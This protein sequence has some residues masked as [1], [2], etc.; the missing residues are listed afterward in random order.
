LTEATF[1]QIAAA[2]TALLGL[3]YSL[4]G[5]LREQEMQIR[6]A[7]PSSVPATR[8][9]QAIEQRKVATSYSIAAG[10]AGLI[11]VPC[12]VAVVALILDIDPQRQLSFGRLTFALVAV[13]WVVVAT[14]LAVAATRYLRST[15]FR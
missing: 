7:L 10:A 4:S 12:A 1:F 6:R 3:A 9:R 15:R 14:R 11:A 5:G 13:L 2:L 8:G